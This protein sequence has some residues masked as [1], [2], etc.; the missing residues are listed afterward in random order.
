M[1]CLIKIFIFFTFSCLMTDIRSMKCVCVCVC[2]CVCARAR[3]HVRVYVCMYVCEK[4]VY[5][6]RKVHNQHKKVTK[7]DLREMNVVRC[8]KQSESITLQKG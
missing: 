3:A 1:Y 6:F 8:S 4:H 2:V 5:K 7:C